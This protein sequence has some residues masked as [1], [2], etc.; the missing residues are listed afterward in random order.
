MTSRRKFLVGGGLLAVAA[1]GGF[2]YPLYKQLF[3]TPPELGFDLSEDELFAAGMFLEKYPAIDTHAHPGRTFVKDAENLT[4]KLKIYASLGTFENRVIGDM[5]AGGITAAGFAA[6]DDF[7]LLNPKKNGLQSV[8]DYAD[9]EAWA[10]YQSQ[11]NNLKALIKSGLV[12]PVLTPDDIALAKASGKPGAFLSVEGANF[13]QNDLSR[14]NTA[15]ADGVRLITAV[16]YLK[17]GPIGDVMTEE[18]VHNG[19]TGFGREAITEL[20]KVGIIVDIAHASEK[21]AFDALKIASKPMVATHTHVSTAKLTHSRFISMELA[22]AIT[23]TGGFIGAWPAGFG[24]ITTLA[25]FLE[26]TEELVEVIGIDHVALGT[27]MDANYK[28]VWAN[29][30]KMPWVVGGLLKRGWSEEDVAK[31]IGGNFMRVFK[32]VQV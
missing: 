9:G 22:K 16:H 24:G 25:Q 6:V 7:P 17:G 23:D 4:W 30:R 20:Q 11:I 15:H 5:V 12:Y 19:L 14:V 1:A 29:Y 10:I 2:A 28:P 31:V 21:T 32:A 26:R 27:D 13:L 3:P 18:S 8:R